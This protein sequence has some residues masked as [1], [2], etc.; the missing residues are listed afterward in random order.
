MVEDKELDV[1]SHMMSALFESR[2]FNLKF[3]YEIDYILE[4]LFGSMATK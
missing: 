1:A 4:R 2:Y 3:N